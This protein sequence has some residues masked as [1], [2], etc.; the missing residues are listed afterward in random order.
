MEID[1]DVVSRTPWPTLHSPETVI[2]CFPRAGSF[3]TQVAASLH[4]S[5]QEFSPTPLG[6]AKLKALLCF[7]MCKINTQR[8]TLSVRKWELVHK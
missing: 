2:G 5:V 1:N 4:F 8:A 3:L 6:Y 7:E